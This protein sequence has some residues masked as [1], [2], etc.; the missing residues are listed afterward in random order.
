MHHRR[1][2]QPGERPRNVNW[3]GAA[4]LLYGDW[5][6]SKAYVIGLAFA[7]C[8][9][10]APWPILVMSLVTALV[11]Y[12]YLTICRLYPHGGGVYASLRNRSKVLSAIGAFLLMADYL[13]TASISAL[14]AFYYLGVSHPV[15]CAF[16]AILVIGLINFR[17]AK[18]SAGLAIWISI[19]TMAVVL[20]LGLVAIPHLGEAARMI[21]P[22]H[23]GL[24][25]NWEN[26]VVI[27]LALS[28]IEAIANST[29]VMKL[30]PHSSVKYP[31]VNFT[32]KPAIYLIMAEVCVMT[33][34]L[35]FAMVALPGLTVNNGEVNAMDAMGVRDYMLREMGKVFVGNQFGPMAGTISAWII[36]GVFGLLLLSAV[37]TAMVALSSLTHLM[38]RDLELPPLFY[39]LNRQGVPIVGLLLSIVVPAGLILSMGD[40]SKLADLYAVG[41]VGAIA[42]N[43]GSTSTDFTQSIKR[44]ERIIMFFTF[45]VMLSLEITL[46]IMKPNARIFALIVVAAGLLL[47]WI[48][49]RKMESHPT[50]R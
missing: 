30:D 3:K 37:N 17:G 20:I 2:A 6:T 33:T 46:L 44:H 41:V 16:T 28:G 43:L 36:S 27:M 32:S 31:S 49:R 10:S 40:I 38:A 25:K 15:E 48:A 4:A 14:S 42:M 11:G 39:R 7:V 34:L 47:R 23:G 45:L 18:E 13:V 26:L 19:P 21:Q 50:H 22:P 12:N 24:L 8:G 9:Y 5:G 1:H 29:G 35:G